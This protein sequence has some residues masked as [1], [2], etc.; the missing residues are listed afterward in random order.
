MKDGIESPFT[1]EHAIR[2]YNWTKMGLE[3]PGLSKADQKLLVNTV[4]KN[5]NL[6]TFADGLMLVGKGDYV[7]PDNN[8][9]IGTIST[10]LVRSVQT[11]KR[12][13]HLQEFI[14][15]ADI[16]FSEENLNKLESQFGKAHRSALENILDRM[17]TGNQRKLFQ[18]QLGQV[19]GKVLDWVNNSVG[20]IMFLNSRSAALQL[21]SSVNYINWS[22]NY[23]GIYFF[24][25]TK[26][27]CFRWKMIW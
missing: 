20:S 19:E 25:R 11:N 9:V 17:K 4:E 2:V 24:I 8:W 12:S 23:Y 21:I 13:K 18:G 1:K 26:Q 3:I 16:I 22:D 27:F 10:D 6:K 7:K 15:N 5:D 14:Q